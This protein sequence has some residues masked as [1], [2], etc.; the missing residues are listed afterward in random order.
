[1]PSYSALYTAEKAALAAITGVKSVATEINLF[2]N[3]ASFPVLF[4]LG[5]V[6]NTE[7]L[8]FPHAT[9]DDRLAEQELTVAGTLSPKTKTNIESDTITLM[10]NVEKAINGLTTAGIMAINM[11]QKDYD[12]D[13]NS[14][15]GYFELVF[16]IKYIYNHLSP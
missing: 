3:A 11:I 4:V 9:N 6:I 5:K 15:Y 12:T 10:S 8:T 1:M 13:V 2:N 14:S 16:S 7:Y